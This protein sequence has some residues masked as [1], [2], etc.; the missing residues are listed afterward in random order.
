MTVSEVMAS[1]VLVVAPTDEVAYL[2]EVMLGQSYHALPVC[3]DEDRAVGIVT[4]TDLI[5]APHPR[6]E[7]ADVM[8]RDVVSI[9]AD[10]DVSDAARLMREHRVH[11]LLVTTDGEISGILST[12][13]LLS[14]V[15]NN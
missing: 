9:G 3:D 13:D 4:S 2:R 12:F 7:V 6:S 10:A 5:D 1:R 11:H 15:E 8:T 14:V